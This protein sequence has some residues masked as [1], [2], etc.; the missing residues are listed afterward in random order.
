VWGPQASQRYK[1]SKITVPYILISL[2][3][4]SKLE[5]KIF[6]TGWK[7]VFLYC[8]PLLISSWMQF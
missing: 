1:A 6:C 8:I 5:D 4:D 7:Q 3:L 2:V